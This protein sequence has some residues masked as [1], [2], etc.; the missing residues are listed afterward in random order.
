MTWFLKV[1]KELV[2]KRFGVCSMGPFRSIS[3]TIKLET[4]SSNKTFDYK[5]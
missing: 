3:K 2:K 5:K 4:I 1:F